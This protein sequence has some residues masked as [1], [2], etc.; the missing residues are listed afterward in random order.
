[1]AW[2]ANQSSEAFTSSQSQRE[3]HS[4]LVAAARQPMLVQLALPRR[5][6][7]CF[8]RGPTRWPEMRG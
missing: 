8:F 1:M 6:V 7:S 5:R 2:L 4:E 3:I